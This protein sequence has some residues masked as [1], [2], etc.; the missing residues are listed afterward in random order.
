MAAMVNVKKIDPPD[1]ATASASAG[2]DIVLIKKNKPVAVHPASMAMIRPSIVCSRHC[3]FACWLIQIAVFFECASRAR[4]SN[5]SCFLV[6]SDIIIS[7]CENERSLHAVSMACCNELVN[8]LVQLCQT[9]S[10]Q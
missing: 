9:K 1:K 6:S 3:L 4:R 7:S 2:V 8:R 10:R 5:S